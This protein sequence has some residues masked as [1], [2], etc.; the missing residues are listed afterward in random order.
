MLLASPMQGLW[1]SWGCT[2]ISDLS[3]PH[4]GFTP[5]H[6]SPSLSSSPWPLQSW[7]LHCQ[8]E[9]CLPMASLSLSS[10]RLQ[11]CHTV[12]SSL[13]FAWS[14]H[15]FK[16]LALFQGYLP[17][18]NVALPPVPRSH[19][20]VLQG[21]SSSSSERK[22][23]NSFTQERTLWTT[24]PVQQTCDNTFCC[25]CARQKRVSNPLEHGVEQIK[26]TLHD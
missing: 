4:Q 25:A 1:C 23:I 12:P 22:S 18:W 17:A 21:W 2:F 15:A 20:K 26:Q 16:T 7:V 8:W 6:M 13:Y 14:C 3:W 10:W 5:C 11:Y 19:L 24:P 9:R